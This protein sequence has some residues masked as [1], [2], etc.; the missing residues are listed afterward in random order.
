MVV[1]PVFRHP[2]DV[3]PAEARGIQQQLCERVRVE[4]LASQPETVAGVDA[5]LKG[6]VG[7]AA[8]V[9]FTYPELSPLQAATAEMSV[10]FPYIP[11]LLAFR[12]GPVVL[13][14]LERLDVAPD[15]L[16]F[17]AQGLAHPR[18]V[19]LATHIGVLLNRPAV[20]CAK[21]R[22]CGTHVEPHEQRGSWSPLVDNDQVIGAVV[23]TRDH[24]RPVFVS[25]GH[26]VDLEGAISLVLGCTTK[27]RLPEPTRWAH[28][29]AGGEALPRPRQSALSDR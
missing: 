11:G 26:L 14:A 5:S 13:A 7:R 17:D 10:S 12:E 9:L 25:V 2:W 8:V 22:L 21:S 1:R 27:Y 19:G 29:V 6:G 4:P 18:R 3:S 20:G 15:V 23:R 24:V 16:M 28:R